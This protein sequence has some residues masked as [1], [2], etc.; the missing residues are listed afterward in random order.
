MAFPQGVSHSSEWH[1]SACSAPLA[2]A[3]SLVTHPLPATAAVLA[4]TAGFS[5]RSLLDPLLAFLLSASPL[6]PSTTIPRLQ[7]IHSARHDALHMPGRP[8]TERN[9]GW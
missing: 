8:A 9:N 3:A 2:L 6:N 5:P 1:P 7:T 4:S